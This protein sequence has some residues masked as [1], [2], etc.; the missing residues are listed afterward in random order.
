MVRYYKLLMA[1]L[2]M[3]V[4]AFRVKN[5]NME[6]AV[7]ET[8]TYD[9]DGKA[10]DYYGHTEPRDYEFKSIIP[11]SVGEYLFIKAYA[12]WKEKGGV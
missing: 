10:T 8:Y 4:V 2:C 3:V 11:D 12:Y 7:F 5:H 9:A 6:S 1:K